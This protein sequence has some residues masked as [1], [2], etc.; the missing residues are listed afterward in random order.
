MCI[1]TAFLAKAAAKDRRSRIPDSASSIMQF[2]VAV[3]VAAAVAAAVA[4]L[5]VWP[6]G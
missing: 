4:G 3:A 2:A 6:A 1:L 5:P